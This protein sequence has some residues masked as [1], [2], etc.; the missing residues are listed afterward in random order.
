M[1]K[2]MKRLVGAAVVALLAVLGQQP[3]LAKQ[4]EVMTKAAQQS[5]TP[6][7]ALKRLQQGNGRFVSGALRKRNLPAGIKATGQGQFPFASVVSCIDSRAAP[8][9]VFDQGVGDIFSASVAGNVLNDDIIGSLEFASKVAGSKLVVIL[10]HTH[11]G[12]VKGA[13]D[14]AQLGNLTQLLQ[15]IRPAVQATPDTH[16]ADR[17]SKNGHFVDAVAHTN[18]RLQVKQL[19]ERSP[20]LREM[21]E[22]GQIK[23]VGA[24]LDVETGKVSF[25]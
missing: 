18:V 8:S 10:G 16:G 2:T 22:K 9:M 4:P 13:C 12:A 23:V 21:A 3:V 11:C 1:R 17:S 25:L 24:M 20:V 7:Q 15:K 5:M 19:L 6:D 14:N